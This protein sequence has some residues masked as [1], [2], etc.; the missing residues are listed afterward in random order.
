MALLGDHYQEMI[1]LGKYA[2]SSI[3]KVFAE[4]AEDLGK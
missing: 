4:I 3:L 2:G 1:S